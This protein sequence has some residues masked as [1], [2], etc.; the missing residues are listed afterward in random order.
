MSQP[1]FELGVADVR[2]GRGI[3]RD[4]DLWDT[5]G[6]W[7]YE[8]ASLHPARLIAGGLGAPGPR[9]GSDFRFWPGK[10]EAGFSDCLVPSA[11]AEGGPGPPG[12][13]TDSDFRFWPAELEAGFSQVLAA[14]ALI[15]GLDAARH[16]RV[17]KLSRRAMPCSCTLRHHATRA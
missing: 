10:N 5:K 6:Q 1:S 7:N 13:R 2:A 3:H 17:H 4:C 14:F 15:G 16:R 12:P 8:R 11:A 9:S